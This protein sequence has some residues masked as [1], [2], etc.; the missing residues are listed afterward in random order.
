MKDKDESL[1]WEAH[2]ATR[3]QRERD[4]DRSS[5]EETI[6]GVDDERHPDAMGADDMRDLIT[7]ML[8][9]ITN[10]SELMTVKDT[11]DD[12]NLHRGSDLEDIDMDEDPI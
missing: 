2:I 5:R 6:P 1:I 9:R 10:I 12:I 8:A 4:P 3:S 11:I 7:D